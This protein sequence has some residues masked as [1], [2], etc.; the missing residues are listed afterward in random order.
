MSAIND[1][2]L[3]KVNFRPDIRQT[4]LF[5]EKKKKKKKSGG[6]EEFVWLSKQFEVIDL[7]KHIKLR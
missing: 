1:V 7:D 4:N 3:D 5:S 2:T 6:N